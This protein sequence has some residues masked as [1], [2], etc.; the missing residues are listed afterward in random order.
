MDQ[1]QSGESLNLSLFAPNNEEVGV[2]GSWN[3]FKPQGMKRGEDGWWRLGLSLGDGEYRYKFKV[4]SRSYFCKDQSVEIS[5]PYAISITPDKAEQSILVV[6]NGQRVWVDYRWEHD[7]TPLA[8]NQDLV[9]YEMHVGDYNRGKDSKAPGTFVQAIERLDHV[10]NLG[11]NCIELMPVKEFPGQTWGYNLRSLFAVENSYGRPEDLCRFVDACHARG[12]RVVVDGVYNHADKDC[13]LAQIDYD[14][15][16]YNPNPDPPLMQWGPKYNYAYFDE[17]LKIFPARKYAIDSIRYWVEKFHI[18]GIRFDATRA[19]A[20][21]D[22]MREL[23]QSAFDM[24]GGCKPF[25]TVAEHVPEDPAITGYPKGPMVAAWHESMAKQLQALATRVEQFGYKPFDMA[26]LV[27]L[28]NPHENGYGS[29]N[30][31]VN[32]IES[33]D[34]ERVIQQ[35]G[36]KAHVFDEAAFR[37]IKLVAALLLIS[38]GLPMIWMGAEF[39][40]PSDKSLDPRPLDWRLLKNKNNSDLLEWYKKLIRIRLDNRAVRS[41]FFSVELTDQ[42]RQV[43]VIKRWDDAGS[44]ILLAV[45]LT[46][47]PAGEFVLE[48]KGLEDGAWHE[49]LYGYEVE[50]KGGRLVDSLEASQAK[51]FI[52]KA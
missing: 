14:Y 25:F 6:K 26:R 1:R 19:I 41:D 12:I 37:R 38:P 9:I 52:K 23:A 48:N 29:G 40:F 21:F 32:Y 49:A 5:D 27:S 16:F 2:I 3:D 10:Q 43:L 46:D 36:D 20:N 28:M 17:K 34:E 22:M 42:E 50:V 33:H 51:V 18:D 31:F 11:C 47:N 7:D 45:N 4:K 30:R 13:P 24:V 15:W 39:G 44:M 35:M 8:D